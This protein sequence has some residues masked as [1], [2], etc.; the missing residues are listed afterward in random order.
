M[1]FHLNDLYLWCVTAV[2]ALVSVTT[3]VKLWSDRD[4]LS[5]EDLTDEDRTFVWRIVFFLVFPLLVLLDLRATSVCCELMGGY[6]RS[7]SY[8][9]LWYQIEPAGLSSDSMIIPV[10]FSGT[11]A[12]CLLSLSLMPALLFR[13][14]PFLATL[15][16][17]TIAFTLGLNLIADPIMSLCGLGG[18]KW[19]LAFSAGS[20]DQRLPL[21]VVQS[22]LAVIYIIAIR[23]S[24]VR[25]WFS[26]F[27]RPM[28]SDDLKQAI[29]DW[30]VCPESASITCKLG[31]MFDR[32]GMR[33]AAK[34]KL[35]TLKKLSGFTLYPHFLEA[36]LSY[37]TRK[38]KQARK[39]FIYT[40]DFPGVDGELKAS[41]LAAAAC[42]AFA[43]GDTTGALNL[44]ERALEFEDACLI[45]RMVKVD[46]FLKQE[47]KQ[48]A[49]E[50]ILVAMHM[51]LS[52][53]LESKI[54]L[55]TERAFELISELESSRYTRL[56]LENSLRR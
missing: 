9:F 44:S 21:V 45:A 11:I 50:E 3:V 51:G 1:Q 35:N 30:K 10:L 31:L 36:V 27:A 23:N 55:D 49:A 34:K 19:Q 37:R 2:A 5:R 52:L 7:W 43:E 16:G 6:I 40:S 12:Q 33:R 39:S 53:E 46:V 4:R 47:K 17:Y 18:L 26:S 41:L 38:Y 24:H 13:P 32:A 14:H 29:H 8:G 22:V 42:A 54:P 28:V 56:H 20:P 15:I 48:A 25:M